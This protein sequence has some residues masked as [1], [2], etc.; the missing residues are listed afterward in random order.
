MLGEDRAAV[1]PVEGHLLYLKVSGCV[2]ETTVVNSRHDSSNV[3]DR[4]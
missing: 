4:D 1:E 2:S 3:Y